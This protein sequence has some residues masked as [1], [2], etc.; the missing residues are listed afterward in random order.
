MK[1]KPNDGFHF[2]HIFHILWNISKKEKGQVAK[3]MTADIKVLEQ[4]LYH[5]HIVDRNLLNQEVHYRVRKSQTPFRIHSQINTVYGH[6]FHFLNIYFNIIPPST[7]WS[8][9]WSHFFTFSHHSPVSTALPHTCYRTRASHLHRFDHPNNIWW[10]LQN[11]VLRKH[12]SAAP[13]NV[14]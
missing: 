4:G 7:L 2:I 11:L 14:T 9:T 13:K 3:F 12:A 5:R 6:L 10:V 8:Y 1:C